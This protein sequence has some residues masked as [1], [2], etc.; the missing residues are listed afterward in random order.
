[1][2]STAEAC[3]VVTVFE[4]VQKH[5]DGSKGSKYG[6]TA[7]HHTDRLSCSGAIVNDRAGIV[8]CS[9]LV[10]SRFLVCNN[11]ISSD[12]QFLSPH[13]ISNKLQ[14]YIE[15]SVRRLV[16]NPLS[17]AVEA[18]RKIS[19]FKA[20][21]VM[22]VN[23]REFQ[24]ALRI[25]FK[26]TD[27][28]SLCCGEDDS[29]LNKDAVFL[30]WFAVLRVPG[31]AKSENGRT[32]PW[33]PSSGLEKGCVVFACGS[34][35]GSL[36]PDLFMSTV[37]KG[38][39]SNLAGEEHAVIL[40][41]ARC[42]PGTEGGGLYVKR[43]DHAHLVGLIVSPL[44]WK[45]GEWIGLT[46]VCSFH[47][48]L[49]NI[50]MVVN[51]R[52]PLKE[53]CAPLHMDSEGVSNKGQCTSMQNYPMVALVDSGQSWGSGVL[54]D[55]Q[56]MLTCRHVLNGKSRLTVRFKTDDRFLVVMGEV[57]Y[58]TKTSSPYDIAV[59]LLKEQLPGIAV[60][61]SGCAFKQGEDVYVISYGAFGHSCGPSVTSG[62]LSRA[63]CCNSQPVMLQTTCA[64]QA[65]ASGGAVVRVYTG[66]LLGLV[67]SNTRDVV[68]G[69]TYPH[70][71][72]SVPFT[73]LEPLLQHFS[74]TRNPAVFQELDTA[75]DEVRR[76]W[77]LQA[78]PKDVPQCKL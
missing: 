64:V 68:T 57:L 51:L 52:H 67:A 54:M 56:L 14:V 4:S 10:F 3:C 19:N 61:T 5:V 7:S 1:M 32:T 29:V 71:N 55:S 66:E 34:P 23:C 22:L 6:E 72:F 37:S 39:I 27:K 38:I 35:F 28:W 76:V 59:V 65:G 62:V 11:S 17:V 20:E 8:L 50:A 42:L 53:L 15:C 26:E 16:T 33:I 75:S 40:T 44:C 73:L 78:M 45:S 24:S 9:G 36:C 13:S 46:L 12:R 63:V 41:D 49:R 2:Q 30:S 58:S 31:L 60:P 43:G 21:L 77:Q 48:I 25:V 18:K 74:V 47:L 70:L 69:V